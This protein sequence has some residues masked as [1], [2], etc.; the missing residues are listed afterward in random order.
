MIT[1]DR[2]RRDVLRARMLGNLEAAL[3]CADATGD[4][5]AGSHIEQAIEQIRQAVWPALD[6]RWD[7]HLKR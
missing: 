5:A 2:T 7:R 6:A 4:A 3:A 1:L